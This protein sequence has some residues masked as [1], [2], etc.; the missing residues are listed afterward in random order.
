MARIAAELGSRGSVRVLT[1]AAIP[2]D[3]FIG[4]FQEKPSPAELVTSV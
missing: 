3:E 1:M 4:S 2:I